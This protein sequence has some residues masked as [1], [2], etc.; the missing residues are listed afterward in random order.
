[1]ERERDSGNRKERRDQRIAAELT[2][3]LHSLANWILDAL[4]MSSIKI[5]V[6]L[7]WFFQVEVSLA[8]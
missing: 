8:S 2:Y 6:F 5:S 4:S 3:L 1:M 7:C